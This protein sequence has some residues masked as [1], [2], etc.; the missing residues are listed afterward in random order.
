MLEKIIGRSPNSDFVI[1]DPKN[2]VSRTHAKIL[3]HGDKVLIQDLKSTNGTYLNGKKLAPEKYH[4]IKRT[5]K[6]T[7]SIDYVFET[8][9]FFAGNRVHADSTK[10]LG[11]DE[12]EM[13]IVFK[14]NKATINDGK[15]TIQMD[16]D[17]T[18]I[19]DISDVDA[20]PYVTIG[21]VQGNKIII[22]QSFVSRNHC[23]LRLLA[24]MI[25]EIEDL[26]SSNGT[27]ADNEKL[28]PHKKYQFT[29]S[30]R[31][32][33]GSSFNLDLRKILPGIQVIDKQQAPPSPKP[34]HPQAPSIEPIKPHEMKAFNELEQYWNE[35][36]ERQNKVGNTTN[37]YSLGGAAIGGIA[38]A[39]MPG[40]G[41]LGALI[42]VGGGLLG[43]YLGQQES[44]KIRGDLTYENAFLETYCCPRCKESFQ[45]KPWITIRECFKC[46]IK[47]R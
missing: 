30:V 11:G 33:L 8:D 34:S 32:R 18:T 6:V 46:K 39:V 14:E 24:P 40:I 13:T 27:Y 28:I 35:Y 12:S 47:F 44:N 19:S 21:R 3:I 38:A 36:V 41:I 7:L 37:S 10:V 22:D 16:A 9:Q 15:R 29:S 43:R 25:I 1:F 42:S 20:T 2:R 5:D 26:G 45:K 4:E 31:I 17:K 23:R